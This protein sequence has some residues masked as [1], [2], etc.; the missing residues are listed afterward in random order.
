MFAVSHYFVRS[1]IAALLLLVLCSS[2]GFS[3]STV[4][5]EATS[6]QNVLAQAPATSQERVPDW[7]AWEMFQR[8]VAFYQRE[9]LSK[10]APAKPAAPKSGLFSE[11]RLNSFELSMKRQF[12]LT[13]EKAAD[14]I[15]FGQ[16]YL[17]AL[18]A[19]DAEA[20]AES[21]RRYRLPVNSTQGSKTVLQRAKEDGLYAQVEQKKQTAL[22]IHLQNLSNK[23]PV[24]NVAKIGQWVRGT[25]APRITIS[26]D[27]PKPSIGVGRE[28]NQSKSGAK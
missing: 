19:I 25:V 17:A 14:L 20:R 24:D 21:I 5:T 26:N 27:P 12:G 3:Q 7:M 15:Q 22:A 9:A 23:F 18:R 4:A 28:P 1:T 13:P 16:A 2:Q 6:I 8:S 10:A 11:K